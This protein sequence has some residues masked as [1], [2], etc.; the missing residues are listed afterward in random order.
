[1]FITITCCEEIAKKLFEHFLQLLTYDVPY[2]QVTAGRSSE[3]W[4]LPSASASLPSKFQDFPE[5]CTWISMTKLIF[6]V[7]EFYKHNSSTSQE[8]WESCLCLVKRRGDWAEDWT[9]ET[10]RRDRWS[11]APAA[12]AERRQ[13]VTV[14]HHQRRFSRPQARTSGR[15]AANQ[16][17]ESLMGEFKLSLSHTCR[18]GERGHGQGVRMLNASF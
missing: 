18:S 4:H 9:R 2:I 17:H 15:Q 3:V 14:R 7:L 8:A 11:Q 12:A 13:C 1:M 6:Q 10:R 16:C 5:P